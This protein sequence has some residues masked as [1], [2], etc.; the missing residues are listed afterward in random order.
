MTRYFEFRGASTLVYFAKF[1]RGKPKS[2]KG[3]IEITS[4]SHAMVDPDSA[5]VDR[6]EPW[7]CPSTTLAVPWVVPP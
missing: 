4:A 2:K 5:Y 7:H 6:A 3:S 1:Q